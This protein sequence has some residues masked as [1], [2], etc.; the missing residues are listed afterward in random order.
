M[1]YPDDFK[2][3]RYFGTHTATFNNVQLDVSTKASENQ[4]EL[5]APNIEGNNFTDEQYQ[6]I[7]QMLSK[8]H[9]SHDVADHAKVTSIPLSL[10]S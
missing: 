6:Q 10:L 9:V 7:L 1:G 2:K 8:Y 5:K 3:K 4:Q